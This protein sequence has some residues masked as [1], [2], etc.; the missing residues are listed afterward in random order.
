MNH[1][2]LF[3]YQKAYDVVDE[4]TTRYKQQMT[5]D[6]LDDY[7]KYQKIWAAVAKQPPQ[8]VTIKRQHNPGY[9]A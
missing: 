7:T 9:Q 1:S 5:A 4:L 8:V 6:E 3:E 2:K